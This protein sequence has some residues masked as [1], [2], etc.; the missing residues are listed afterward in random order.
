MKVNVMT[1]ITRLIFNSMSLCRKTFILI[2]W[3]GSINVIFAKIGFDTAENGPLKVRQ[4]L[5]NAQKLEKRVRIRIGLLRHGAGLHGPG[6]PGGGAARGR[7]PGPH[8]RQ[9]FTRFRLYR[10]R[11]LQENT[12][13]SACF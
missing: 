13:F 4:Q 11:S 7:A 3:D 5:A 1:H 10:H 2:F 9:I 6:E 8:F 12:R